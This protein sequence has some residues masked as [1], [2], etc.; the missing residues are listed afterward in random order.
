MDSVSAIDVISRIFH[1]GTAICIAGGT[2]FILFVLIPALRGS[3][4]QTRTSVLSNTGS[5]WKRF[6]HGGI[7]LLIVTGFYNYFLQIKLHKGDGL[8]HALIGTKIILAFVVF[9][10]AEALVGKSTLFAGIR[11][12]RKRYLGIIVLMVAII[13]G[14]SGLLKVRGIPQKIAVEQ[15]TISKD[16]AN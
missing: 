11:A 1:V 4:E 13:V 15:Q 3:D 12:N 16:V 8:Y 2:V 9:F 7:L 5:Y 6:V 10:L 14:I